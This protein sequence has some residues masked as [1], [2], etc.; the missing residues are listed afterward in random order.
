[1]RPAFQGVARHAGPDRVTT[2]A[3]GTDY[4]HALRHARMHPMRRRHK[5]VW[6]IA[7]LLV[8][9]AFAGW[10]GYLLRPE[11][12]TRIAT[13]AL[14]DWLGDRAHVEAVAF[15]LPA[16]MHVVGLH[17][18]LDLGATV[19][20]AAADIAC[21]VG[22]LLAGRIEPRH[23]AIRKLRIELDSGPSG[24]DAE[25]PDLPASLAPTANQL[26][27]FRSHFRALPE[28]DVTDGEFTLRYGLGD[29]RQT[30][31][32]LRTSITA[33][34]RATP[35]G[36][37]LRV[38][39]SAGSDLL[40]IRYDDSLEA[41]DF[42]TGWVDVAPIVQVLPRPLRAGL[43]VA[44]VGGRVRVARLVLAMLP[45]SSRDDDAGGRVRTAELQF[46]RLAGVVST[47]DPLPPAD[48]AIPEAATDLYRIRDGVLRATL[49]NESA[50]PA[51]VALSGE[52]VLSG[53]PVRVDATAD[54][55]ALRRAWK[56]ELALL[57]ALIEAEVHATRLELPT[58]ATH[59]KLLNSSDLP[60]PV[61]AAFTDFEPRGSVDIAAYL[62]PRLNDETI[63]ERLRATFEPLGGTCRYDEF[64]YRFEDVRG[65]IRLEGGRLVLDGLTGRHGPARVSA[66]GVLSNTTQWTGFDLAFEA[67]HVPLDDAL[68][69]ALPPQ[70]RTIWDQAAPRGAARVQTRVRRAEG[71][72]ET[73]KQ[74]L[75]I[76]VTAELADASVSLGEAGR[77]ERA[78][79]SVAIRDA[80][81]QLSHLTGWLNDAQTTLNGSVTLD[82]D[83]P[84]WDLQVTARDTLI[85]QASAALA[86]DDPYT[87]VEPI[88]LEARADVT[89]YVRGVHGGPGERQLALTLK[90]GFIDAF[91]N[92]ARWMIAAGH[93]AVSN[94]FV[95][96]DAL[97]ARQGD[98]TIEARATLPPPGD[99]NTPASVD[100]RLAGPQLEAI[101]PQFAPAAWRGVNNQI[102]LRGAGEVRIELERPPDAVPTARI[103]VLKAEMRSPRL[104][105]DLRD[106]RAD[107]RLTPTQ[108]QVA[109]AAAVWGETGELTGRG[110]C[111]WDASQ[112]DCTGELRARQLALTPE[113]VGALPSEIRDTLERM[114]A[115]GGF[116]L[117]L[118]TL[119][120]TGGTPFTWRFAGRIPFRMAALR[121]GVPIEDAF[122]ELRGSGSYTPG[123]DAQLDA[124]FVLDRAR[125]EGVELSDWR[126]RMTRAGLSAPVRLD[127]LA[128]RVAGGEALGTAAIDPARGEYQLS[129]SLRDVPLAALLPPG[130]ADQS[131]TARGRLDGQL[132]LAGVGS[133]VASRRGAGQARIRGASFLQA[134]LLVSIFRAS[135]LDAIRG[136]DDIDAAE[137]MFRWDGAAVRLTRVDVVSREIRLIG[138]GVWFPADNRVEMTL[139]GAH[140]RD[141]PRLAMVTD[142]IESAAGEIVQFRV[143]G[144][145]SKPAVSTQPLRRLDETLR[146]LLTPQR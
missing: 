126:G 53:A 32:A 44:R 3:R 15:R 30:R 52:A 21:G 105:I 68:R 17:A 67:T 64:P 142:L 63:E 48:A 73:G 42:S 72:A 5:P 28:I 51:V 141:W 137:I 41:L 103:E 118:D 117:E 38:G 146:R 102:G 100:L 35:A 33:A 87:P 84:R 13:L 62:A 25:T 50:G 26:E 43:E 57:D 49:S 144:T 78:A 101:L 16:T 96:I 131:H 125:A 85:Q 20:V 138:E 140:P 113:L 37:E 24:G 116:S 115:R 65:P 59:P 55:G 80:I 6:I 14:R 124:A 120:I 98:A 130:D 60:G 97:S 127:E 29:L 114:E 47:G 66:R 45:S 1:M 94:D 128:G 12:L 83:E 86:D 34:G 129:L 134:P 11:R 135:W 88:R 75:R 69:D 90:R 95:R 58:P 92:D 107:V 81:L 79:G 132:T 54:V 89:G 2:Q 74:P 145:L 39:W 36:Y 18:A 104:P 139:V 8:L 99:P 133:D 27:R 19:D 7:P 108:F 109:S 143:S 4:R 82:G 91:G 70:Y 10:A 93:A 56:G 77:L 121:L 111:A 123:V 71:T 40:T 106:V 112:I 23:V 61:R 46:D 110:S 9:A 76:E 119:A 122:G 22:A 31:A 136:S